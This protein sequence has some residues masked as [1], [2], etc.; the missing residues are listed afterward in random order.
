MSK[1]RPS[2]ILPR[3]PPLTPVSIGCFVRSAD[4]FC[5]TVIATFLL[6]DTTSRRCSI[7]IGS[8]GVMDGFLDLGDE[9]I[10]FGGIGYFPGSPPIF[11]PKQ[12]QKQ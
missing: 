2:E 11:F 7:L 10:V 6:S 4:T 3:F 1:V 12:L 9:F 8:L 5:P